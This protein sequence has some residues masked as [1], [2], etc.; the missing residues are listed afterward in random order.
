MGPFKV[1]K[2]QTREA[3]RGS[4]EQTNQN[5]NRKIPKVDLHTYTER[6]ASR[7]GSNFKKNVFKK[8]N[9]KVQFCTG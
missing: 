7:R 6:L 9:G 3:K 1:P 2:K 5:E 8:K 4:R